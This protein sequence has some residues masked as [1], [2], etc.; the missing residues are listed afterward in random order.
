MKQTQIRIINPAVYRWVESELTTHINPAVYR[1]V[2]YRKHPQQ[3]ASALCDHG[4]VGTNVGARHA[5]PLLQPC[6]VG[7]YN[8]RNI[9]AGFLHLTLSHLERAG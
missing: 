1:W 8:R 9:Q 5:V 3:R 6:P 7:C 2:N 4:L